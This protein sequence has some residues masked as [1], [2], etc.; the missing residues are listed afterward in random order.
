[1]HSLCF[2]KPTIFTP[3]IGA[4]IPYGTYILLVLNTNYIICPVA[5]VLS[6]PDCI[7]SA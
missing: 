2:G 1:L 5:A 7:I 6:K 3:T 4:M